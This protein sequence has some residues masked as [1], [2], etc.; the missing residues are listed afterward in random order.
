M[1]T[2]SEGTNGSTKEENAK[3]IKSKLEALK[4]VIPGLL[5]INVGIDL[6]NIESNFDVVLISDF[7]NE[8]ALSDYQVHPAHKEAGKF[9]KTVATNRSCVDYLI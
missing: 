8:K 4:D 6:N 5:N 9:I 1:W 2:I 7:E 3:I